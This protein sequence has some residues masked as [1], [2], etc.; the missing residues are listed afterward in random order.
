MQIDTKYEMGQKVYRVVERFRRIENIQACNI[1]SGASSINY[2]GY[3]CQCPKCSGRGSIVLSSED[4]SFRKVYEPKEITSIRVT[5][6]DKDI[7]IRYRVDGEV[8]PEKELFLTMEEIE[9]HFNEDELVCG[10]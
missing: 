7:N 6:S 9:E 8:V 5:V 1:C 10:G 2:K 4:V 3:E